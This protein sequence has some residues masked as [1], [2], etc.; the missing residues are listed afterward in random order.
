MKSNGFHLEVREK[1]TE[2]GIGRF[3]PRF[4]RH[5]ANINTFVGV[6]SAISMVS[7]ILTIYVNTQVPNLERQFG[8][9]STQSGLVMGFNDIGFFAV[10]LFVSAAA[11]YVHIPRMLFVCILLYGFSGLI[12]SIPHFV[13]VSR[14]LLPSLNLNS[15]SMNTSTETSTIT[16]LCK[17]ELN[18]TDNV[19]EID[20]DDS[21]NVLA[22]PSYSIKALAL[23]LIGVGMTLQ[24][25]GKAPRG[26]FYLVYIDDNIERRKTG[27][28]TSIAIATSIFGPALAFGVGGY[29][30]KIYVTLE[31]VDMNPRDPRWIGAWWLGFVVFGTISIFLSSALAFFPRQLKMSAKDIA[32]GKVQERTIVEECSFSEKIKRSLTSYSRILRNPAYLLTNAMSVFNIMSVG[33]WFGFSS[34]FLMTHFNIPLSLANYILACANIGAI[35]T[36]SFLGG[37]LTRKITMT[38]RNTY[39]MIAFFYVISMTFL[40]LAMLMSC[41]QPTVVG[42]KLAV[43]GYI[44][45]TSQNCSLDCSCRDEDFYPICGS[46]KVNY[47]SPCFAGCQELLRNGRIFTNCSC[48]PDGRANAGLCENVCPN[49]TP[50][51]IFIFLSSITASMKITPTLIAIIRSVED[52][53]K[54]SALGLNSCLAAGLGW[55]LSPIIFGKMLDGTCYIWQFPCSSSGACELYDLRLFRLSIHGLSLA[56]RCLP[57]LCLLCLMIITRKWEDWKFSN[58]NQL[59]KKESDMEYTKVPSEDV[60]THSEQQNTVDD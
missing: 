19:C 38:P 12:C 51:V 56:I 53:D 48:I 13:A 8:L 25:I 3:R 9:S 35:A 34:K 44:D 23:S 17:P 22:A 11:R 55:A 60:K 49:L 26:P 21:K 28:Y 5:F 57:L 30:S 50:W 4:L 14:G 40:G 58:K 59:L 52:K 31:D 32:K 2:C 41:P 18:L 54:A 43:P 36:G 42:P 33:G 27:F 37:L 39:R 45:V 16:L 46:N 15:A 20:T 47:H 24:G 6:Y 1:N 29:F 7:Q 10:V